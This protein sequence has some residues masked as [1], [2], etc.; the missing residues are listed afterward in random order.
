MV[1]H[2]TYKHDC[3]GHADS[4]AGGS[5]L[6]KRMLETC[7]CDEVRKGPPSLQI[8]IDSQTE[9]DRINSSPPSRRVQE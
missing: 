2:N 3:F 7:S 6:Q 8:A 4:G 5:A 1:T 9:R